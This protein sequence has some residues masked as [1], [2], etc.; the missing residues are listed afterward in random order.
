MAQTNF[1]P[2]SLYYST[3]AAAVPTAGNLVAGE[4]AINT[5]DGRLFYKDSAGV[6]QTLATKASASGSFTNL[7]YTGTLTGGTGI[8]NLGSG[9]FYKDASGNVG[10]GSIAPASKLQ[11]DGTS[12]ING[13]NATYVG[14]LQINESVSTAQAV[15]GLEFKSASFGSGYG[16]KIASLDS[17]GAQLTFNNRQNSTT[18]SESMRI[19]SSGNLLVGQTSAP[20]ALGASVQVANAGGLGQYAAGPGNA[21]QTYSF[22][23]DNVSTGNFVFTYNSSVISSISASTG[24]YTPLSDSRVK[25]NIAPLQYGL[26][27]ILKLNPVIYNMI[28]EKDSD[29]KHI[30]L[31]AQQVK[32][33]MDES[34]DDLTVLTQE[35]K[36]AGAKEQYYGLDKSGLVPVLIKAI[37]ELNAKVDAQA[38]EIAT[39][40]DK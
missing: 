10:I 31:I 25:K 38:A 26:N 8:V 20:L 40:K 33:V 1:T 11:I 3:T 29:K 9:Q 32:E 16:W 12:P 36:D 15:G 34:V 30:G 19:N 37:Q 24:V 17:T 35:M 5:N 7:A 18:W 27:E 13:V 2:I 6:V 14:S 4:L 21:S 28:T 39:L 22:G 23:R